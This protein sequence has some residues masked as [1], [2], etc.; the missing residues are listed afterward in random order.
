[1]VGSGTSYHA[2]SSGAHA[3]EPAASP[4]AS[5]RLAYLFLL[6]LPGWRRQMG[7]SLAGHCRHRSDSRGLP[8]RPAWCERRASICQRIAHDATAVHWMQ[9]PH[10][11]PIPVDPVCQQHHGSCIRSPPLSC[12]RPPRTRR[13]TARN[14]PRPRLHA[15]LPLPARSP[16]RL[17]CT[18]HGQPS[19]SPQTSFSPTG[20]SVI[21]P[22]A[23]D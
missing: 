13:E 3:H 15:F 12:L 22:A 8:W 16:P 19:S 2:L 20:C 9:Y 11:E 23:T 18:A 14:T 1:V 6:L 5:C 10:S 21:M 17:Y 7:Q 4:S